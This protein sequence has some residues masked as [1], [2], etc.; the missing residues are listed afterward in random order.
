VQ[1]DATAHH[2]THRLAAGLVDRQQH[3]ARRL[4]HGMS[5]AGNE[6]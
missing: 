4:S 5:V 3:E 2:P 6:V 1:N